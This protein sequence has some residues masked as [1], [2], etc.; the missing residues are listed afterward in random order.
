M[1]ITNGASL[2][3][4]MNKLSNDTMFNAN[5]KVISE[6]LSNTKQDS[7]VYY[8]YVPYAMIIQQLATCLCYCVWCQLRATQ[9]A[10][11]GKYIYAHAHTDTQAKFSMSC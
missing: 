1:I 9:G 2:E 11:G 8:L 6:I 5:D 10:M 3:K 7:K 4:D